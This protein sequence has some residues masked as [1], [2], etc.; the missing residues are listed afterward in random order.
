ME[1]PLCLPNTFIYIYSNKAKANTVA[2]QSYNVLCDLLIRQ[3]FRN[4]R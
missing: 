2:K 1:E 4:S 3:M